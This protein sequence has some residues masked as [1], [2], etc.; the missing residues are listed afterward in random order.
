MYASARVISALATTSPPRVGPAAAC[1]LAEERLAEEGAEDVGEVAEVE[2]G[3][4]EPAAA[5]ALAPVA[6]VG[7][8]ALGIGEHLVRLGRLAEALLGVG[9]LR[10]VGM[11]LARE[12]AERPL[13]VGVGRAAVDAENLVVV[14]L[15][16]RHQV[17]EGTGTGGR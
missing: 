12:L 1:L 2:V 7:C 4:R 9:R 13:D 11:E 16:R 15:G 14:A 3:R 5:Q 8:A 17:F 6:V 10:D